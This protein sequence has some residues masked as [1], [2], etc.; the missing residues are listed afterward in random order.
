MFAGKQVQGLVPQVPGID[1]HVEGQNQNRDDAE[2]AAG[3]VADPLQDRR[4]RIAAG[5]W[6]ARDRLLGDSA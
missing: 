1:E 3:D 5:A 4:D 2:E 6:R